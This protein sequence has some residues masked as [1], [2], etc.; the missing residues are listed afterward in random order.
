MST[1]TLTT[2][3]TGRSSLSALEALEA[4][5]AAKNHA[6]FDGYLSVDQGADGCHEVK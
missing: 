3:S 2:S 1:I 4:L 6:S 5:E